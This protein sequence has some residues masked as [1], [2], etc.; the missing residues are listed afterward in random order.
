MSEF[1][2]F[3]LRQETP[4]VVLAILFLISANYLITH[5]KGGQA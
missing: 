3:L 2:A 1:L 4:Q 5:R